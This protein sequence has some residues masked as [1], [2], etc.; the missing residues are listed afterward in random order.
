MKNRRAALLILLLFFSMSSISLY[1][2]NLDG[3][4]ILSGK[5]ARSTEQWRFTG[6]YQIR[7]ND[8]LRALDFHMFE[9]TS[10]YMPSPNWEI[11]PDFRISMY[12]DRF[13]FRPGFGIL[14]K[15]AWGKKIF[16]RQIVNQ[17]KWQL[18]IT[19]DGILKNGLRYGLFY[20]HVLTKKLMFN[21]GA[22]ILYRWSDAYTGFQF[23]RFLAGLS[24]NFDS[25]HAFNISPYF[26]L[27]D[28]FRDISYTLGVM[29]IFSMRVKDKSKYLPARYVSF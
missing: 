16:I 14:Y 22:A 6:D 20:N 15:I 5:L 4:L 25:T 18:D 1:A 2:D 8:D 17:V 28:P 24:I 9:F 19:S 12:P 21:S 27:E 10:T 3:Q 23:V 13:E 26:G 7:L 11:V 29:I